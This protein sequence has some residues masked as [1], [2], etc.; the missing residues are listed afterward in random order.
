MKPV[1]RSLTLKRFRS[2]DLERVELDNP[3]FLVGQN[4]AG[5]S[6]LIDA[7]AF[8]R[9]AMRGHPLE[10]VIRKRGGMSSLLHR[11]GP[12]RKPSFGLKVEVG[13]GG[14]WNAF[15]SMEIRAVED[16]TF[17]V[18]REQCKIT[19]RSNEYWFNRN[20]RGF[21]SNIK[22]QPKPEPD[23]HSL[24]LPRLSLRNKG[25]RTVFGLLTYM[26]VFKPETDLMRL[27]KKA[28]K[29]ERLIPDCRSYPKTS[30]SNINVQ[31][32]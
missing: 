25:F 4:A 19:L 5:K 30:L 21:S 12:Q 22:V 14:N 2:F 15:Y 18:F 10:D 32:K 11:A 7:F 1:I 13:G 31:V 17:E 29:D 27:P 23:P 20:R 26:T 9:E 8:L 3:T 16:Q 28:E 24:I 6:N